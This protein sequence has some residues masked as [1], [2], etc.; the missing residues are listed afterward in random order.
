ME[1]SANQIS[2]FKTLTNQKI[3]GTKS[4]SPPEIVIDPAFARILG[5]GEK[6]VG[7]GPG[8]LD[9]PEKNRVGHPLD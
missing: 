3:A 2:P 6:E 5:G 1:F 9:T 4:L 8:F 7:V